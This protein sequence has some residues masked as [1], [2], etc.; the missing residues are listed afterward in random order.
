MRALAVIGL[1]TILYCAGC[2]AHEAWL[3]RRCR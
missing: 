2:F 1:A 3:L